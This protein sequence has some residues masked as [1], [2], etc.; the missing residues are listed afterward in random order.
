MNKNKLILIVLLWCTG[1]L[2][3]D[4]RLVAAAAAHQ[5]MAQEQAQVFAPGSIIKTWALKNLLTS[6]PEQDLYQSPLLGII[7]VENGTIKKWFGTFTDAIGDNNRFKRKFLSE[8][9][10]ELLT[11]SFFDQLD[12]KIRCATSG[13]N[14]II[15]LTSSLTGHWVTLV[16]AKGIKGFTTVFGKGEGKPSKKGAPESPE[17]TEQTNFLQKWFALYQLR[18]EEGK[19]SDRGRLRRW[20]EGLCQQLEALVQIQGEEATQKQFLTLLMSYLYLKDLK[21]SEKNPDYSIANYFKALGIEYHT[22]FYTKAD[23]SEIEKKIEKGQLKDSSQALEDM[24]FYM[25]ALVKNAY[26][27]LEQPMTNLNYPSSNPTDIPICAETTARSIFNL[28]LYNFT[29]G[30]FDFSILPDD[31]QKTI[32]KKFKEFFEHHS[33]PL[34]SNYYQATIYE[35]MDFLVKDFPKLLR[36]SHVHD[37]FGS[38]KSLLRLCN[39][40][41]G[42]YAATFEE[43]GKKLSTDTHNIVFGPYDQKTEKFSMHV[44]DTKSNNSVSAVI[45]SDKMG[46]A[47]FTLESD[48]IDPLL[49]DVAFQGIV[50]L[51]NTY[52]IDLTSVAFT[53]QTVNGKNSPLFRTKSLSILKALIEHGAFVNTSNTLDQTALF[54]AAYNGDLTKV[55]ILLEHGALNM[56][57]KWGFTP[58]WAA[59]KEGHIAIVRLMQTYGFSDPSI[60]NS[61][62]DF[63]A[64]IQ[65]NE[66]ER[67]ANF[68]RN[69]GIDINQPNE[70]GETPL[71]LAARL[72]DATV[73][74]WL[75]D[76]GAQATIN[77]Q[78]ILGVTPL[79]EAMLAGNEPVLKLLMAYG[80]D[81]SITNAEGQSALDL[82]RQEKFVRYLPLLEKANPQISLVDAITLGY[83]DKVKAFFS[84]P[85]KRTDETN[86]NGNTALH[87][88]LIKTNVKAVERLLQYG[89]GNSLA[90]QNNNGET[91]LFLV[92][93]NGNLNEDEK[94]A[95]LTTF[96]SQGADTTIADRFGNTPLLKAV[97]A[98]NAKVVDF[99]LANGAE[100]SITTLNIMG[101]YPLNSAKTLD[102]TKLL[103][104]HGADPRRWSITVKKT[105]LEDA[106][107]KA[108]KLYQLYQAA[109]EKLE[110]AGIPDPTLDESEP[111]E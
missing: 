7:A 104:E 47:D 86:E 111:G 98:Q 81:P 97:E 33:N 40:L 100:A 108:P 29:K 17:Q 34:A 89:I 99:L 66:S 44:T 58:F 61:L 2:A 79:Y 11:R 15:G 80:A 77:A 67:I 24:V 96:V 4:A 38:H 85:D 90:I 65:K 107:K 59:A 6:A 92:A 13:S 10:S 8:T 101:K 57:D 82:A 18:T 22:T 48:S 110:A 87:A 42:T 55:S 106:K 52:K 19:F 95:L 5:A 91:P 105:L 71:A 27:F 56:P 39:Y 46:H 45:T 23:K 54:E 60:D 36:G 109:V 70:K 41:F 35:W 31:V 1:T 37:L 74:K 53:P 64:A 94:I 73:A 30:T 62:L 26:T 20:T 25:T 9:P 68:I 63:H 21:E 49:S 76:S 32:N 102:M 3:S 75:I 69:G 16:K 72:K 51:Q 84:T 88:A 12:G 50:D 28:I 93:A 78:D 43:L 14:P 103:L 83:N